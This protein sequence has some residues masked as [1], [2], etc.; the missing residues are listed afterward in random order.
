MI[1]VTGDLGLKYIIVFV[2]YRYLDIRSWTV[3]YPQLLSVE[4]LKLSRVK[5]KW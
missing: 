1:I 3:G 4:S 5:L 2:F